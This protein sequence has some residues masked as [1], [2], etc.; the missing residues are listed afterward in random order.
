MTDE[1][2]RRKTVAFHEAGHAVA[3]WVRRVPFDVV[4]IVKGEGY[5]G[6]LC[7][8]DT[9]IP[10]LRSSPF[11]L[12]EELRSLTP[13]AVGLIDDRIVVT[14]AGSL[15]GSE[16]IRKPEDGLGEQDREIAQRLVDKIDVE[17][18]GGEYPEG[19]SGPVDEPYLRHQRLVTLKKEAERIVTSHWAVTAVANML[20]E[21]RTLSGADV[22]LFM[23][24]VIP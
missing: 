8:R 3:A 18:L 13:T 10:E 4:T 16:F 23:R 12:P 9:P 14:Y 2:K 1:A 22:Q 6:R 21:R 11:W 15:A 5:L 7:W 19:A 20:L 17:Y 24:E